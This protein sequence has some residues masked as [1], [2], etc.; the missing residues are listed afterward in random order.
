MAT[1][2]IPVCSLVVCLSVHLSYSFIVIY[3]LIRTYLLR[4]AHT[5]VLSVPETR[6]SIMFPDECRTRTDFARENYLSLR[7]KAAYAAPRDMQVALILH[8]FDA[9]ADQFSGM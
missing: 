2:S 9:Y 1:Q 4:G 6:V 8:M 7:S 3:S 5:P